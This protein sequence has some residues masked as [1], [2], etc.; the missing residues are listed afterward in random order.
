MISAADLAKKKFTGID[1][2]EPYS[3]V[4]GKLPKNFSLAI[5]GPAGSGKSTVAV[6]LA[7]ILVESLGKGIYC[8][9]EEG[10]GPSMQN[11]IKRLKADHKD[12]FVMDFEGME[13][14]KS[15]IKYS[16]AKFCIFDS[17]S[18]SHI[19]V[20]D[21]EN[22][23]DFCKDSEVAFLYI[24][25]AT[26]A[27]DFKGNTYLIH[28]PD[29]V[30]KVQDGIAKTEKNRFAETP[31]EFEVRF[32]VDEREN[33]LN[34]DSDESWYIEYL[35]SKNKFRPSIKTF[36]GKDSYEKAVEWGKKNLPNFN[37]DMVRLHRE[38]GYRPNPLDSEFYGIDFIESEFQEDLR[39][40]KAPSPDELYETITEQILE[41][42]ESGKELPW[43]KPWN[44]KRNFPHSLPTNFISK[45]AYRGINRLL[46]MFTRI[47]K[48][49]EG[50]KVRVL[51]GFDHP[52]YLT[53]KQIDTLGGRIKE[54]AVGQYAF[55][56]NVL[57]AY[58]QEDPELDYSTTDEN[59]FIKW[60]EQNWNQIS[61]DEISGSTPKEFAE[62]HT[63]PLLRYYNIFNGSDIEGIDFGEL[64]APKE[65]PESERIKTGELIVENYPNPPEIEFGGDQPAY[66][67]KQDKIKMTEFK[68]FKDGQKYYSVFF[69]ELSHSTGH[70]SRLD[71][72]ND[73]RVRDGSD[74]DKKA[75][76]FE[77][78]VAEMSA[79]FLC[80]E[81]GILF[82]TREMTAAYLKGY[83]NA[84]AEYM[85]DDDR[86]FFRATSR[87]QAA[88]DYILDRDE[89]GVPAYR[90]DLNIEKAETEAETE[91]KSETDIEV[92]S[93]NN[94]ITVL[95][96]SEEN[97]VQI[98]F[99]SKPS[100]EIRD[101]L[102]ANNFR[103]APSKKAWQRK[104]TENARI[105]AEAMLPALHNQDGNSKS[106][107]QSQK[108]NSLTQAEREV[109]NELL[110]FYQKKA[111]SDQGFKALKSALEKV[112]KQYQEVPE[113]YAQ[114]GKGKDA[115][116]YLHAFNGAS[117]WYITEL[118]KETKEAFGFTVLDQDWPNA[119][120]G[121][122]S[123]DELFGQEDYKP[124]KSPEL[125]LYWDTKT[126]N[127]VIGDRKAGEAA[128][129]L[130]KGGY[131]VDIYFKTDKP[132]KGQYD[133]IEAR[134]LIPSHNKDCSQNSKHLISKAQ[135][136]DRS[137]ADLCNQSK[138]MAQKLNPDL[139]TV[140]NKAFDGA[141][142]TLSD[143]QVIQGNGRSI[144]LKIAY[145]EFEKQANKY[146][147]YLLKNAENFGLS[148]E[149]VDRF[150]Q[151]VLIRKVFVS[152]DEAIK[153]G[154][155]VD[156]SQAKMNRLDQAKAYIRQLDE[157]KRQ[158]IGRIIN[159]SRGE[160]LGEILDDKGLMILDQL[161]DLDRTGLVE[162]NALT[163][164]GKDFLKQLF[165]G[166][167]FDSDK[168][169]DALK[170]FAK[171]L[172]NTKAGIERS[173][174]FIIPFIG[175]DRDI[176]PVLQKSIEIVQAIQ[177]SD[178]IDTIPDFLAQGDAFTGINRDR[179]SEKEVQLAEFLLPQSTQIAIKRAFQVYYFK[180]I[181]RNDLL[182]PIE[183]VSPEQAFKD[184]FVDQVR[185]NPPFIRITATGLSKT[186]KEKLKELG[187]GIQQSG[188]GYYLTFD[189]KIKDKV[190]KYLDKQD[191]VRTNPPEELIKLYTPADFKKGDIVRDYYDNEKYE[192]TSKR[193]GT[194]YFKNV[195]TGKREKFRKSDKR[196]LRNRDVTPTLS[197]F[198]ENPDPLAFMGITE[199][200]TISSANG[201]KELEGKFPTF[202]AGNK[203]YIMPKSRVK[204]V[205]NMVNDRKA[206]QAFEE[207]NNYAASDVDYKIDFPEDK[208][209][210]VGTAAKIWYASDK[211]IQEG[212]RKGK[213]NHYVHEF[214]AG[215][216]P[217]VV[218]GDVL[219]IGNIEWD[220]RGLLN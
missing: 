133:I 125:D 168:N 76:K 217:A 109:Y 96:N 19:K 79:A 102:K 92:I 187:V 10:A 122:M 161:K 15:A 83:K 84:L 212:D 69:H 138:L 186:D 57:Y 93:D 16:G 202:L 132:V 28:M 59:K 85:E 88:T 197:L 215:K 204:K 220:A 30:L 1:L 62:K 142:V 68:Q 199:K 121:Y 7:K 130:T 180:S 118:D 152:E 6:D 143:G 77:E 80:A 141:P 13:D 198:R 51:G 58:D 29:T 124:G 32:E 182:N 185:I 42:M 48:N 9:S 193:K 45:K 188:P 126:I 47:V 82:H 31:Q 120:L 139:I 60:A 25:H 184:A 129:Q 171:L 219:I 21:M 106:E 160:T 18:M 61:I 63:Y 165:A 135:P 205:K 20:A 81:A 33:P 56:F 207:F 112:S 209:V 26:K 90:K 43:Q 104:L 36:S 67:P 192:M 53:T 4:L 156:T 99:D 157:Q 38:N 159:S 211:V 72:G 116:I 105:A 162:N 190:N 66:Y 183:K 78:L 87:A 163:G 146:R 55:Y 110:P 173:Y 144:A 23:H 154:N 206:V 134:D 164:D 158:I 191:R 113:L 71:R 97:R 107:G 140:G 89:N 50:K 24:L 176:A 98:L 70:S 177:N 145:D 73:T 194:Y 214:D 166:L 216:R 174:G 54:G 37:I 196:F 151:P 95:A 101:L 12:L 178:A 40:N 35:D 8:S 75:Y 218:K 170:H 39:E 147:N 210:P 108:D 41:L 119:E 65:L 195:N 175:T 86:F 136:R 203:L 189:S 169:K 213:V 179:F 149:Y 52:Y 181:G 208:S 91:S 44:S 11:K 17:A 117:D 14:L 49:D 155:I 128:D 201:M 115:T 46:L 3:T 2:P 100:E 27:G 137:G 127:E 5:W 103:W 167:V 34:H 153:L 150:S 114:D 131:Q 64:P 22:I 200:V 148:R 172:H 94:G 111:L 123:L 74:E